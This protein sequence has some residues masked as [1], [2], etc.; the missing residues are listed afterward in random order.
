[1]E[2]NKS[3]IYIN[4][5]KEKR[6]LKNLFN[7]FI[8]SYLFF[9]TLTS[10]LGFVV[11]ILFFDYV[12]D[13]WTSLDFIEQFIIF[14]LQ[15]YFNFLSAPFLFL[16]FTI[17]NFYSLFVK[18]RSLTN[19]FSLSSLKL[20]WHSL[21]K[22]Y[23]FTCISAFIILLFLGIGNYGL[24]LDDPLVYRRIILTKVPYTL[25]NVIFFNI[26]YLIIPITSISLYLDDLYRNKKV[27]LYSLKIILIISSTLIVLFFTA[28]KSQ[29]ILYLLSLFFCPI[30]LPENK[31]KFNYNFIFNFIIGAISIP[32]I[33][34]LISTFY[35]VKTINSS[36]QFYILHPFFRMA[37]CIFGY[38]PNPPELNANYYGGLGLL[39]YGILRGESL[40]DGVRLGEIIYNDP[41]TNISAAA[42]IRAFALGGWHGYWL[43]LILLLLALLIIISRVRITSENFLYF[44]PFTVYFVYY[45]NQGPI[46]VLILSSYNFILPY[47]LINNFFPYKKYKFKRKN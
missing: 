19:L 12:V 16:L 20:S 30:L 33:Y 21:Y 24:L 2:T 8:I 11:I 5:N 17:P 39:G 13:Q 29:I 32:I 40:D 10:L 27:K 41:D 25:F 7:N 26:V 31:I 42:Q 34:Y 3:E 28:Q 35:Y 18:L 9:Y 15:M 46:S 44:I 4:Q 37:A 6:Y 45:F 47:L 1:M 23:L 36:L 22:I 43:A 38:F 14:D